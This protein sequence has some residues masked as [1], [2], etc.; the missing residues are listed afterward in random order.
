VAKHKDNAEQKEIKF[1]IKKIS[2]IA[3]TQEKENPHFDFV[4]CRGTKDGKGVIEALEAHGGKNV[5]SH[6]GTN[7]CYDYTFYIDPDG[8]I[9]TFVPDQDVDRFILIKQFYTEIPPL[10]TE[11]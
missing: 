10:T 3:Q 6:D 8:E 11:T 4:Y 5:Y 7:S 9:T 1:A 2:K